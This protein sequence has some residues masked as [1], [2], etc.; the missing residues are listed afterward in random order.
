MQQNREL[1]GNRSIDSKAMPD[2]MTTLGTFKIG[3]SKAKRPPKIDGL[4]F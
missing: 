2:T 4:C 3:S 1:T